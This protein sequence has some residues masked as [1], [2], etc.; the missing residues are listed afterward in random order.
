MYGALTM[1][2]RHPAELQ[3]ASPDFRAD[4]TPDVIAPFAPIETRAAENPSA[5]GLGMEFGAERREKA[6]AGRRK[7]ATI[8][9]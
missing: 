1:P 4:K 6:Q 3:R 8:L 7:R 5:C 2:L 9:A